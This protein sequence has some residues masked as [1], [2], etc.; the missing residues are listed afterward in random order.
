MQDYN[1]YLQQNKIQVSMDTRAP[2]WVA[3][4]TLEVFF[5]LLENVVVV[6]SNNVYN[7]I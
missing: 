6:F 3:A 5:Q 1:N 7:T 2:P 4:D